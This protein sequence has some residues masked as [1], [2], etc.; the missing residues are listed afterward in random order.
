MHKLLHEDLSFIRAPRWL[1]MISVLMRLHT[2]WTGF[3][4]HCLLQQGIC[5]HLG[6]PLVAEFDIFGV[7]EDVLYASYLH[8]KMDEWAFLEN[9]GTDFYHTKQ[10][11]IKKHKPLYENK[12]KAM[13]S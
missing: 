5:Y 10:I 1:I 8:Y 6:R 7:P 9:P 13:K 12:F 2:G 4:S 11:D 3:S